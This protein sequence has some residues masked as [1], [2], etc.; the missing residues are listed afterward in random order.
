MSTWRLSY[1]RNPFFIVGYFVQKYLYVLLIAMAKSSDD[2]YKFSSVIRH[3]NSSRS[4][5]WSCEGEKDATAYFNFE[6]CNFF[7]V[8]FF[9]ASVSSINSSTFALNPFFSYPFT[10]PLYGCIYCCYW[11]TLFFFSCI[12]NKEQK[13]W[14]FPITVLFVCSRY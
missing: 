1:L 10:V 5:T 4:L 11:A 8:S 13:K 3:M 12:I 7:T 9:Q 2:R 6:T 14:G